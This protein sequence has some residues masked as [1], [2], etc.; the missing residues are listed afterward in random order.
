MYEPG[1]GCYGCFPEDPTPAPTPAPSQA[2]T[3]RP[4]YEGQYFDHEFQDPNI[5]APCANPPTEEQCQ[6]LVPLYAY[7]PKN[8][9][10]NAWTTKDTE[11]SPS[12]CT[13]HVERRKL[14]YNKN[15]QGGNYD[16]LK[17]GELRLICSL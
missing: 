6:S 7:D 9:P 8:G 15:A 13:Y 10:D 14:I 4:T 11:N 17:T 5:M 16:V 2:P 12:G 1:I 3:L